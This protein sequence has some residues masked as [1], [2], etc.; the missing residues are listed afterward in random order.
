[1]NTVEIEQAITDL[2][3]RP[4]DPAKFPF[5]FLEAFGD[6]N[7]TLKKLCSGASNKSDLDGINQV[8]HIHILIGARFDALRHGTALTGC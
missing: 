5:V 4:F 8:N 1:M 2:A 6:K 7:A 3:E